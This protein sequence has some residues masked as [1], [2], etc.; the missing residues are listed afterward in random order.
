MITRRAFN[1][2]LEDAEAVE[3]G[4]PQHVQWG[5]KEIETDEYYGADK[6]A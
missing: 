4:G 2:V 5:N 6:T 3:Q 1:P